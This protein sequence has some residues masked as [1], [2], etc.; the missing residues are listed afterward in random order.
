M[1]NHEEYPEHRTKRDYRQEEE[2]A[3]AIA[4]MQDLCLCAGF[5]PELVTDPNRLPSDDP[6]FNWQTCTQ[7]LF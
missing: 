7:Q 5:V 2:V 6:D 4:G 1:I 3:V